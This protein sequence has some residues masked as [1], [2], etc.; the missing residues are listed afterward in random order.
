MEK[1]KILRNPRVLA[2]MWEKVNLRGKGVV[3]LAGLVS[4]QGQT[5]SAWGE[6]GSWGML[7]AAGL[8]S[9]CK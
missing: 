9:D 6:F 2:S 4:V 7:I 8:V 5:V 1:V 3:K